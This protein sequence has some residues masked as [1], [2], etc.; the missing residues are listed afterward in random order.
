[1][2]VLVL[3]LGQGTGISLALTLFVLRTR[4]AEAAGELSGMAQTVG[5]SLAAGGP[6]AAGAL[7]DATGGWEA[8]LVVLLLLLVP[9]TLAGL[10]AGRDRALEDGPPAGPGPTPA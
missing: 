2:A 10:H 9:M 8:P 1:M 6:L 4:T 7:H 3:G 5:Y